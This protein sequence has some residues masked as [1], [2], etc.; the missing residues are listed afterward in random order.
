[1]NC[2]AQ[3]SPS[4]KERI[5]GI[6]LERWCLLPLRVLYAATVSSIKG[7]ELHLDCKTGFVGSVCKTDPL[8]VR[9][10]I[11]PQIPQISSAAECTRIDAGPQSF[12][13]SSPGGE[14]NRKPMPTAG[15]RMLL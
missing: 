9:K 5:G 12:F 8:L 14:T 3:S 6:C 4:C 15:L 1:M 7:S 2:L 10:V 13:T 11:F